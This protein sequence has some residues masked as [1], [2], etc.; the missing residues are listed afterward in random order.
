MVVVLEDSYTYGE[1]ASFW[2]PAVRRRIVVLRDPVTKRFVYWLREI[3][4]CASCTFSSR[5]QAD[6][7]KNIEIEG[8]VCTEVKEEEWR[9]IVNDDDFA[10]LIASKAAMVEDEC[11]HV[12]TRM[13]GV[14]YEVS[15]ISVW[16]EKVMEFVRK[17]H[18]TREG[19]TTKE[20]VYTKEGKRVGCRHLR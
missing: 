17:A 19:L 5:T 6:P 7:T 11:D 16:S 1:I 13:F 2:N 8:F 20:C 14:P 4:V 10:D 15:G 9:N 12:V 18:V 3:Y